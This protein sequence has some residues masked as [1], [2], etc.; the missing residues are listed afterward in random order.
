MPCTLL[1]AIQDLIVTASGW[2]SL[3]ELLSRVWKEGLALFVFS[4]HRSAWFQDRS[5]WLE[6][7]ELDLSYDLSVQMQCLRWCNLEQLFVLNEAWWVESALCRIPHQ[8]TLNKGPFMPLSHGHRSISIPWR[9]GDHL[10]D[11]KNV[12]LLEMRK[13]G[14]RIRV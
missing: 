4:R 2:W 5:P 14:W 1:V 13:S 10:E 9:R 12:R 6:D 8:S 7:K 3:W 11:K